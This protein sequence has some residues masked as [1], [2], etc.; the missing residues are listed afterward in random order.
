MD[1]ATPRAAPRLYALFC[2]WIFRG[3]KA[4]LVGLVAFNVANLPTMFQPAAVV[5]LVLIHRAV[6]PA[7]IAVQI[8]VTWLFVAWA[9][10][11]TE[12]QAS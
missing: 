6:L 3:G 11:R 2:W 8:V 10:R 1:P 4:L 5:D 9:A 12:G 7:L